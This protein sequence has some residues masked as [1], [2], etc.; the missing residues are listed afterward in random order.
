MRCCIQFPNFSWPW[1][2]PVQLSCQ[3]A[4]FVQTSNQKHK[5]PKLRE[6]ILSNCFV[7]RDPP[8]WPWTFWFHR[9]V[10][11][12]YLYQSCWFGSKP[13]RRSNFVRLHV[14][15][16]ESLI[17]TKTDWLLANK[18]SHH[19][20]MKVTQP[21]ET[22]PLI[23]FLT[24]EMLAFM[25]PLLPPLCEKY[26]R[27]SAGILG[28]APPILPSSSIIYGEVG[29]WERDISH[30][31]QQPGKFTA[32]NTT[33][34]FQ[35]GTPKH[36]WVI[37]RQKKVILEGF[38][39]VNGKQGQC[40]EIELILILNTLSSIIHPNPPKGSGGYFP[41]FIYIY[42][43]HS[44]FLSISFP[45]FSLPLCVPGLSHDASPFHW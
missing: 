24:P 10:K 45:S 37:G 42:S 2:R 1:K 21:T 7:N 36:Y 31:H 15:S 18:G 12:L 11:P 30:T 35:V 23:T 32:E 26:G 27:A 4:W 19:M 17:S 25:S 34:W 8:V 9:P 39:G 6:V 3:A 16:T 40:E 28:Y 41:I 13:T 22:S 20:N 44:L 43:L 29:Q 14:E 38:K 33:W 5:R